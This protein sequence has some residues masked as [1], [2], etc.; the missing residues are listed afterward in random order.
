MRSFDGVLASSRTVAKA[1][2]DSGCRMPVGVLGPA[3]RRSTAFT[4]L[5][6]ER[7][8]VRPTGPLNL[9]HV[10]SGF[11]RKGIDVLLAAYAAA[12]RRGDPVRLVIKT[13]PNPHN[14]VAAQIARTWR[15]ADPA[16]PEIEL[17][18][19]D[20]DERRLLALYRRRPM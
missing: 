9:L 7:P 20:L 13:F 4:Q 10:S 15:I 12:F 1:L 6:D 11:P 2:I 16:V 3:P 8:A 5:R 18:D 14:D 19:A 17:I